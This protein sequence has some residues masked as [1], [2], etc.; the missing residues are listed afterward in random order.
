MSAKLKSCIL[1]EAIKNGQKY[2]SKSI[3]M[4]W[5]LL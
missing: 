4:V 2:I 1:K 3:T 5:S